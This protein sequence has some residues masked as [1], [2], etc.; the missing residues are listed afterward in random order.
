[1][2]Q[3][4]N[5]ILGLTPQDQTTISKPQESNQFSNV[6]FETV[7]AKSSFE[8]DSDQTRSTALENH[9]AG[10]PLV[11]T[12]IKVAEQ[13]PDLSK[14]SITN[15]FSTR[16]Q[17]MSKLGMMDENYNYTD[18]YTNYINK[19]GAPLPG[20]EYA[21]EELLAQERYDSIFQKVDDGTMSYD[22]AL[23]EAYGKDIMA[24]MGYDVTSVAYWQNKFLNNDFSNP[25]TNRYLM[26]QVKAAAEEYHQSRLVSQYA[27]SNVQSTQ[28]AG[29]VGSE[30]SADKIR[31][32]FSNL[33]EYANEQN[34]SDQELRKQITSGQIAASARLIPADDKA[35]SYYYLHTDGQMYILDNKEGDNH[36]K[37]QLD[38]DGQIKEISLNSGEIIDGVRHFAAGAASVFTGLFKLG[39]LVTSGFEALFTDDSYMEALTGQL[40]AIDSFTNDTEALNWLTDTGHIDLDG[41]QIDDPSDWV[42]AVCDIGGMIV[43]GYALG[44]VAG[45]ISKGGTALTTSSN[46]FLRG[47]GHVLKATGNL[48]ARSTGMYAG[49]KDFNN[50]VF[51]IMG[52]QVTTSAWA[53]MLNH[54]LKTVPT[55]AMKDFYGT[56]SALNSARISAEVNGQESNIT[57]AD[58]YAKAWQIAGLNAAISSVF[59]GGIN[60]NQVQRLGIQT[61]TMK[62]STATLDK[63]GKKLR[64]EGLEATQKNLVANLSDDALKTFLTA[65]KQTIAMNTSMDLIDNFMTM[66]LQDALMTTK[67]VDGKQEVISFKEAWTKYE[68]DDGT[69][70]GAFFRPENW[71][72]NAVSAAIMTAPTLK[73]QLGTEGYNVA[74][75][76]L[77]KVNAGILQKFDTEIAKQS[78][79]ENAETLRLVKQAYVSDYNSHKGTVEE[80]ILYA[81]DN[82]SKNLGGKKVPKII[83]E[84]VGDVVSAEKNAFYGEMYQQVAAKHLIHRQAIADVYQ[85]AVSSEK[86]L[87]RNLITNRFREMSNTIKTATNKEGIKGLDN[88]DMNRAVLEQEIN[89]KV[90]PVMKAWESVTQTQTSNEIVAK[91]K[92]DPAEMNF[93]GAIKY[94]PFGELKMDDELKSDINA[95]IT[96]PDNY[97]YIRVKNEAGFGGNAKFSDR[98]KAN[99]FKSSLEILANEENSLYKKVNDEYYAMP[100]VTSAIS[101]GFTLDATHK[102]NLA[103]MEIAKGNRADG[104]DLMISTYLGDHDYRNEENMIAAGNAVVEMLEVASKNNVID[105]ID[106][107]VTLDEMI[108]GSSANDKVK[109]ALNVFKKNTELTMKNTTSYN[110]LTPLEKNYKTLEAIKELKEISTNKKLFTSDKQ[111]AA[112]DLLISDGKPRSEVIEFLK[113]YNS[114]Y[115]DDMNIQDFYEKVIKIAESKE[116]GV[117]PYSSGRLDDLV[118][119]VSHEGEFKSEL[120]KV[121]K[122]IGASSKKQIKELKG[123]IE[124]VDKIYENSEK[125]KLSDNI[126]AI[127]YAHDFGDA[128]YD[129][130]KKLQVEAQQR[131]DKTLAK[132][133][134]SLP[135]LSK[136]FKNKMSANESGKLIETFD[137][138]DPFARQAFAAKAQLLD[139]FEE[140]TDLSSQAAIQKALRSSVKK[141]A[142]DGVSYTAGTVDV[143]KIKGVD[144]DKVAK[145]LMTKIQTFKPD[146]YVLD[147]ITNKAKKIDMVAQI[148][149]AIKY[150]NL[151]PEMIK[152]FKRKGGKLSIIPFLKKD[153]YDFRNII[154][155]MFETE[156]KATKQGT[157]GGK[158]RD[159]FKQTAIEAFSTT[160]ESD[161]DL[162]KYF[163][164]NS[165]I[166][167]ISSS[168]TSFQFT[169]DAKYKAKLA[170]IG[171]TEFYDITDTGI[172]RV[173]LT[174]KENAGD[175]MRNYLANEKNINLFKIIPMISELEPR[176]LANYYRHPMV[177][178]GK[179]RFNGEETFIPDMYLGLSGIHQGL[180]TLMNIEFG[181]D[182]NGNLKNELFF[183]LSKQAMSG[184]FSYDPFT[185][186]PENPVQ[187]LID[188]YESEK[189]KMLS[190]KGGEAEDW[191]VWLKEEKLVQ[192][193]NEAYHNGTLDSIKASDIVD[194]YNDNYKLFAS[195]QYGDTSLNYN[196]IYYTRG[197]YTQGLQMSGDL[198]VRAGN[199]VFDPYDVSTG[200]LY[201]GAD[202]DIDRAIQEFKNNVAMYEDFRVLTSVDTDNV[203]VF[204][205][206]W[207][208]KLL[209]NVGG[210]NGYFKIDDAD[211]VNKL[212]EEEFSRI[213]DSTKVTQSEIKA[214][215]K[216][217]KDTA[218]QFSKFH[219]QGQKLVTRFETPAEGAKARPSIDSS[220]II[221]DPTSLDF[222]KDV[223]LA[224]DLFRNKQVIKDSHDR[225]MK[226]SD[227]TYKAGN[228]LSEE[229][230]NGLMGFR[231]K[232]ARDKFATPANLEILN[233]QDVRGFR[234]ETEIVRGTMDN[235]KAFADE[236]GYK[237]DDNQLSKL[238]KD[239]YGS[240]AGTTDFISEYEGY[241]V[242]DENLNLVTS[243]TKARNPLEIFDKLNELDNL[244]GKTFIRLNKHD[245]KTNDGVSFEYFKLDSDKAIQDLKSA[246]LQD[247]IDSMFPKFKGEFANKGDYINW[248]N[249][250]TDQEFN[251]LLDNQARLTL[252][253]RTQQDIIATA[254]HNMIPQASKEEIRNI[255]VPKVLGNPNYNNLGLK[256]LI[257]NTP[258]AEE[259]TDPYIVKQNELATFGRTYDMLHKNLKDAL[260]KINELYGTK[261]K[262]ED[263]EFQRTINGL[264]NEKLSNQDSYISKLKDMG[265]SAKDVI[266]AAIINSKKGAAIT[267]KTV[268][269]LTIKDLA[270]E[271]TQSLNVRTYTDDKVALTQ[272]RDIINKQS[273]QKLIVYDIEGESK[274]IVKNYTSD[275]M[276]QIALKVYD[277]TDKASTTQTYFILHKD[278][279][280]N[281]IDPKTWIE[282]NVDKNKGSFY[283][284]TPAYRKA[285]E[286]YASYSTGGKFNFITVDELKTLFGEGNILMAY[287]GTGYDFKIL[288]N[289]IGKNTMIDAIELHS[290]MYPGDNPLERVTQ[291]YTVAKTGFL[292]T[293]DNKNAA[294]DAGNDVDALSKYIEGIIP[295]ITEQDLKTKQYLVRFIDK[296]A[297]IYKIENK[298]SLYSAT[299]KFFK[300]RELRGLA[301]EVQKF[302]QKLLDASDSAQIKRYL[303]FMIQDDLGF[304]LRNFSSEGVYKQLGISNTI[305]D[306]IENKKYHTIASNIA[307]IMTSKST[308]DHFY[309]ASEAFKDLINVAYARLGDNEKFRIKALEVMAS[310]DILNDFPEDF[311]EADPQYINNKKNLEAN[312]SRG[313]AGNNDSKYGLGAADIK[314]YELRGKL[315]SFLY[316]LSDVEKELNIHPDIREFAMTRNL[317]PT[318]ATDKSLYDKPQQLVIQ[319]KL[320]E[321]LVDLIDDYTNADTLLVSKVNGIYKMLAPLNPEGEQYKEI[322]PAKTAKGWKASK[323]LIDIDPS[324][325]VLT[326]KAT[327]LIN[328][329]R[330]VSTL[331]DENG[332][333]WCYSLAYPSDKQNHL[334]AHK[335]RIVEGEDI[336]IFATPTVMESLRARDFDGDFMTVFS[337]ATKEQKEIAKI[338]T[339]YLFRA[340]GLQE[341]L[342]KYT[343]R[344]SGKG[345]SS[346][347][348][349]MRM[350]SSPDILNH[351]MKLDE[352]LRTGVGIKEAE[353][354]LM[355]GIRLNLLTSDFNTSAEEI[356]KHLG[357]ST[358]KGK[359]VHV[360]NPLIYRQE[361]TYSKDTMKSWL[362]S[363]ASTKSNLVDSTYGYFKKWKMNK[364][365]NDYE[366]SNP[367]SQLNST[368]IQITGGLLDGIAKISNPKEI[369]Q[370]LKIMT[371]HIELC[372]TDL[373]NKLF[374]S[375]MDVLLKDIKDFQTEIKD[376]DIET[377]KYLL[378]ELTNAVMT[379]IEYSIRTNPEFNKEVLDVIKNNVDTTFEEDLKHR[380]RLSEIKKITDTKGSPIHKG[381]Y[382]TDTPEQAMLLSKWLDEVNSRTGV[383]FTEDLPSIVKGNK[384]KVAV[385]LDDYGAEDTVYI[386]SNTKMKQLKATDFNIGS[387]YKVEAIPNKIATMTEPVHMTAAEINAFIKGANFK[388]DVEVAE[389]IYRSD[390]D[391]TEVMAVRVVELI[392]LGTQKVLFAGKGKEKLI[393]PGSKNEVEFDA[394]ISQKIF[395]QE[396]LSMQSPFTV[397]NRDVQTIW[398]PELRNGKTVQ[399]PKKAIIFDEVP[400]YLVMDD[401][402]FSTDNGQRIEYMAW[403]GSNES[404]PG[405]G[406]YGSTMYKNQGGGFYHTD[407]NV[408]PIFSDRDNRFGIVYSNAVQQI[409]AIKTDILGQIMNEF[410]L[411]THPNKDKYLDDSI[412]SYEDLINVATHDF[413]IATEEYHYGL[414]G[415][416]QFI[417][418][419]I[420]KDKFDQAIARRSSKEQI[421]FSPAMEKLFN[422]FSQGNLYNYT[423]NKGDIIKI[424]SKN[425]A[426]EV[427]SPY[428]SEGLNE[429]ANK[430]TRDILTS[431]I[432][433]MESYYIPFNEYYKLLTDRTLNDRD[434]IDGTSKG[435]L[436]S[437]THLPGESSIEGN[438]KPIDTVYSTELEDGMPAKMYMNNLKNGMGGNVDF[439]RTRTLNGSKFFNRSGDHSLLEQEMLPENKSIY[440]AIYKNFDSVNKKSAGYNSSES[441]IAYNLY[442]MFDRKNQ[443][444]VD[445]AIATV[446][447]N[448]DPEIAMVLLKNVWTNKDGESQYTA[449]EFITKDTFANLSDH[450][451]DELNLSLNKYNYYTHSEIYNKYKPS[452]RTDA[453][454]AL[455]GM[456]KVE[457]KVDTTDI[458][459]D[460]LDTVA[461]RYNKVIGEN[462]D[463]FAAR[464]FKSNISFTFDAKETEEVFKDSLW[465]GSGIKI[466][467]EDTMAINVALKNYG[468]RAEYAK[469]EA[470]KSLATLNSLMR[471]VNAKDFQDYCVYNWLVA[472]RNIS[473]ETLSL[474][475]SYTDYHLGEIDTTLKDKA[476]LF[477]SKHKDVVN[478]YNSYVTNMTQLVRTAEKITN[479]P[480][481]NLTAILAPFKSTN[482]EMNYGTVYNAIKSNLDFN[483][484]DPTV[485]ENNIKSNMVFNFFDSANSMINQVSKIIGLQEISTTLARQ[486]LLDNRSIV[487]KAYEYLT[488]G[489]DASKMYLKADDPAYIQANEDIMSVLQLYTDINIAKV[490]KGCKTAGERLQR[491]YDVLDA[492]ATESRTALADAHGE[493]LSLSEINYRMN[494]T[495]DTVERKMYSDAYNNMWA[496]VIVAQRLLEISPKAMKNATDFVS[497]LQKQGYSLCNKYG[498]KISMD[499]PIRPLA[500]SSLKFIGDNVELYYN[501]SNPEK[502]AQ[503]VIEKALSGD[504]YLAKSDLVDQLEEKVYTHKVPSRLMSKFMDISKMSSS[505][506]M[507]MPTKILGRLFRFTAF[508]YAMGAIY[509]PHTIKYMPI[510]AK[511][512]AQAKHTDGKSVVEGSDLYEYFIR[513]GQPIGVKGKD[514]VTFSEDINSKLSSITDKLTDPLQVQNHLGRYAIY[515][516]A[517]KSFDEGNPWYG[518]VYHY[519]D[520]IDSLPTNEDKAMFIMDY[521][522]GSPGGFPYLSKKTSGLMMYSTFPLNLTRTMGAWGMSIGRLAQEGFTSENAK[523]WMKNLG[524]P[525]LGVFAMTAVSNALISYICDLYGVDEETEEEW[526]EKGVAIDPFGTI[527]G[528]SPSVVYDSIIPTKNL[529]EMFIEP[530]TSKYNKTLGDKMYGLLQSNIL[531]RLN[532]AIKAPLEVVTRKDM[533]GASAYDTSHQYDYAENT[534]RKTLGFFV[535]AGV[536]NNVINQYKM[537]EYNEDSTFM[538]SMWKGISKGISADLGNQKS[539]KKQTSNYYAAINSVRNFYNATNENDFFDANTNDL[540]DA[541]YLDIQRNTSSKYG[542]YNEDDFKRINS[543]VRNMIKGKESAATLYAYIVSEY[544][545]GTTEA[546]LRA[547]LN[548]NSIIRKLS[549]VDKSK[550]YETLSGKELQMIAQAIEYEEE[551]YPLLQEFF[552]TQSSYS[553]YRYLPKRT[554]YYGG[555]GGSNY[556]PSSPRRYYPSFVYPSNS[557]YNNRYRSYSPYANIDRVSVRVSPEMAVWKNDYNAID[558]LEK[559]EWYLDNP[560]YNSLSDY[561]KRQKGGN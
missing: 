355:T 264:V 332:E 251:D 64:Q 218:E 464:G 370:M 550:F 241:K 100:L 124:Q 242:V 420:G 290:I 247:G 52:K 274:K 268:Q 243:I 82:L 344:F 58:I 24:T 487:D 508:D 17:I 125:R 415:L 324:E 50:Q 298:N 353:E 202:L 451:R 335:L 388:N 159:A 178:D 43:G 96:D 336:R 281:I 47:T 502:F 170:E 271:K 37:F 90:T 472:S 409:Q 80:K 369:N 23:M 137:L 127:N 165:L 94:T 28:A 215:Y 30:V 436:Y 93:E 366:I 63:I 458:L 418:S 121:A 32:I 296:V 476:K 56:V 306:I 416:K 254:I 207:V 301:T 545:K 65:R 185:T 427:V 279:Q 361:G 523:H 551:F 99:I 348:D 237:V 498:Q 541:D 544:N 236:V 497:G 383:E 293:T 503:Y 252:S 446:T 138:S 285:L 493:W 444:D 45:L 51:S 559:R 396:K 192:K 390:T 259:A 249:H 163:A 354:A 423:D 352:A 223:E 186:K 39:A 417:I 494:N 441:F 60:D 288:N 522:L 286:N 204:E 469:L 62:T 190:T 48:A 134:F 546:T 54:T 491:L 130:K 36:G 486:K 501:N 34:L 319:N 426:K 515:L 414:N 325:I 29:L 167:E 435:V 356:Y 84:A 429:V 505:L 92:Y 151:S 381:V 460:V 276:F 539:W 42:Y 266:N 406:I 216:G 27:H 315:D 555:G 462:S 517:K 161:P 85:K 343:D 244:K 59:A 220:D 347:V 452:E 38:E 549:K 199:Y 404:L 393:T 198:L 257:D 480:F 320:A 463:N 97:L 46:M 106:A 83:T 211:Y 22:T 442:N 239:F 468:A 208:T 536:A 233:L 308:P 1:M 193:L 143:L 419:A 378:S 131:D 397:H 145:E 457:K 514:A 379:G 225:T 465:T 78:K 155:V 277:N 262:I 110:D 492:K 330:S 471:K 195:R 316:G 180:D 372:K 88:L 528:D 15:S 103:L 512:I 171:V 327:E 229:L 164:I 256:N 228:L 231:D 428:A 81:M 116:R 188:L 334:M 72:R 408:K 483:S 506:Q 481:G 179:L 194:M 374:D 510:A 455:K 385:L 126:V 119:S 71:V 391:K 181:W 402:Q 173:T 345:Q 413:Y 255:L 496:Q 61:K 359:F 474:R 184:N 533:F 91:L 234:A 412:N 261:L 166:D 10:I 317:A 556:Y 260:S 146:E 437:R 341:K 291:E 191:R 79:P 382:N 307:H 278:L 201:I 174:L 213:F 524:Y 561:E 507:S 95:V 534:L 349:A 114:K 421:F 504:I 115:N 253:K 535:G 280:G 425:K 363:N 439:I 300:D 273:D 532:P 400:N 8:Q 394:I 35:S 542:E 473:P 111:Q 519:K 210:T 384:G 105:D 557:S 411:W 526:K 538:S 294:H 245:L 144:L 25:F 206:N 422:K 432:R 456:D 339:K 68:D 305:K 478:A 490:T 318:S 221:S 107:V 222:K 136:E 530:F 289:V 368:D 364:L 357:L 424:T 270:N 500:E 133:N 77:G 227:Q 98:M 150:E 18:T 405:I 398:V 203:H 548:S 488:E 380:M 128:T 177:T 40:A 407:E 438:F 14:E 212:T 209:Q 373:N 461:S 346:F 312:L 20:Y 387:K 482:K 389:V 168:P 311:D 304:V 292:D 69:Q 6:N 440:N 117:N 328:G 447:R 521:M 321:R 101:Q 224:N 269:D 543:M 147:P 558:D 189:V 450:N 445:R 113:A 258:L 525:S 232:Q 76:E 340:Q 12:K 466:V 509:S 246:F 552:P 9:I 2:N 520:Q 160:V 323:N 433:D 230:F 219:Q 410:N 157:L 284:R 395:K 362:A 529:K 513:E 172:D 367:L 182:P 297:D 33:D 205:E 263:P 275:E 129:A 44:S 360:M 89:D 540:L 338:S 11:D 217:L 176:E 310:K 154:D 49:A 403:C 431:N 70:K 392:P 484:Y 485:V 112:I 499:S 123:L 375:N 235:L 53:P 365:T 475:A 401:S 139:I 477:E 333:A 197:G 448:V 342:F 156:E 518:P 489:I 449:K 371:D 554:K 302:D 7:N 351:C 350:A 26:D 331:F 479:E 16:D 434:I 358:D 75:Q 299:D 41:F 467:G 547:V 200:K 295:T 214:I 459:T 313:L 303:N 453:K 74:L 135:A 73:G 267:Y 531:S 287:N 55:Y 454:K 13:K 238:A 326:K 175:A 141:S 67:M 149:S 322:T 386:N 248:L 511:E 132:M 86:G 337:A 66:N 537:D 31:D 430:A 516:A 309:S 108:N 527:L 377:S 122:A 495:Q 329:G 553:G 183:N 470:T 443:T 118:R 4:Q 104:I 140:G 169:I 272:I 21:H 153:S 142:S 102:Y 120:D 187:K 399:V 240:V 560:F 250:R 265:Y 57:D 148:K 5:N 19:G 158:T 226:L 87:I 314:E 283:S 282:Q 109:K 162:S 3:E 152:R 376:V 196:P